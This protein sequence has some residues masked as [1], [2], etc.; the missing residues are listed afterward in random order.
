M[1]NKTRQKE[2]FS[3]E[4]SE[5]MSTS[6]STPLNNCPTPVYANA[7]TE[8]FHTNVTKLSDGLKVTSQAKFG[9]F[10]TVGSKMFFLSFSFPYR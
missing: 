3:S 8:N 4:V 2:I 9:T 5:E 10:C 6:L 7:E 1:S